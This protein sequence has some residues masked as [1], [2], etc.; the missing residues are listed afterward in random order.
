MQKNTTLSVRIT[1]VE[2][3]RL[4]EAAA[5]RDIPVSQFIREAIKECLNKEGK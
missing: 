1:E 2:K 4:K 3:D 5:K